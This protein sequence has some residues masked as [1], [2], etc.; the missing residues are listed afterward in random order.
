MSEDNIATKKFFDLYKYINDNYVIQTVL[1]NDLNIIFKISNIKTISVKIS[2][3]NSVDFFC[4]VAIDD[5]NKIP[6]INNNGEILISLKE[7]KKYLKRIEK[8]NNIIECPNCQTK[9][10][11]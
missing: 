1:W 4:I 6:D 7:L 2:N 9:F 10:I 8:L 3:D 5:I 11:P